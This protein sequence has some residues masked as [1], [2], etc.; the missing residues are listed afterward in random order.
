MGST[1]E[2]PFWRNWKIVDWD[3]K[4]LIKQ[5]KFKYENMK[6]ARDMFEKGAY[7]FGFDLRSG[8]NHID[9]F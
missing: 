9:I 1:Q 7:M 8:Y 5:T 2:D 3:V 4:N 6:V